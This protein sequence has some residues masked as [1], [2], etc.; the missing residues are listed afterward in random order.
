MTFARSADVVIADIVIAGAGIAGLS[1]ALAARAAGATV[2]VLERAPLAQRGGNTRFSNGAMRAVYGGVGDIERW[3]GPLDAGQKARTEFGSYPRQLYLQDMARITGGRTD[4]TLCADLVDG[5]AA[6][7]DWL[8]DHGVPFAPLYGWQFHLPDGR[9]VFQGGS[10][11]E[12]GGGGDGLSA[13]LFTA[14]EHAGAQVLYDSRAVGLVKGRGGVT[15]VVVEQPGGARV[16]IA[17]HAVVLACGGFEADAAA[18]VRHLGPAWAA[19]KVR[20]SRFNTG[21]GLAMALDAG[22]L[23]AGDWSACHAAS[24]D[25]NAPDPNELR[26]GTQ[27]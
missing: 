25:A 27:F 23:E 2:I 4:P 20:G 15:G 16:T 22:A 7:L 12:A 17:A 21:D 10:A 24:W 11:V 5:S 3:T 1:A 9:I 14:V 8:A 18:R 19:A 26:F 6:T 13:A